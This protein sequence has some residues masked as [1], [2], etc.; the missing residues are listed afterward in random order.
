MSKS[1]RISVI[2]ATGVAG[3]EVV[4]LL[5]KQPDIE[6]VHLMGNSSAGTKLI[7]HHPEIIELQDREIKGVDIQKLHDSDV[8]FLGVPHGSS[9]KITTELENS[10][11][12]GIVIDLGADHR[13]ERAQDWE[14]FYG[15]DFPGT[16]TYGLPE[17]EG[18]RDLLRNAKRIAVPGCNVTAITLGLQPAILHGLIE[19]DDIVAVLANGYSGAGKTLQPHLLA[20]EAFENAKPYAVGGVHRHI[21]EIRQNIGKLAGVDF[22]DVKITMTPTLVPMNRGIL[23]TISAKPAKNITTK[24]LHELCAQYYANEKYVKVLPQGI[25]PSTSSVS[26][27]NYALI[28]AVV[29]SESG[30]LTFIVAIDNLVRGTA[31]QAIQSMYLALGMEETVL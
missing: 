31:G 23:A 14:K 20:L 30:R 10:G 7:E 18:Q 12:A 16:Y 25:F 1:F 13:L 15:G 5:A 26:G 21:P 29:D 2:G 27:S 8:V 4:R 3:G 11:F 24:E 17:L 19:V 6:L 28:Q 22:D 9:A